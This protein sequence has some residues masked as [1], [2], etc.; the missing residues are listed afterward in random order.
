M[1]DSTTERLMDLVLLLLNASS[2]LTINQIRERVP[3]YGQDDPESF[4][5]MFERDKKALREA[6]IPLDTVSID[7]AQGDAQAYVLSRKDWLIPDLQLTNRERMLI[8][9]AATGWQ[10]HHMAQAAR[11]AAVHIGGRITQVNSK[12]QLRLGFD[13]RNLADVLEAIR[14]H[15]VLSFDYA[16]KSSGTIAKRRVDPWQA[17]CRSGAWY[18]IGFDHDHHEMRTFRISRIQGDVVIQD[19]EITTKPGSDFSL[20]GALEFWT[21]QVQEPIDVVLRVKPGTCGHIA[22][23]ADE[24]VVGHEADTIHIQ[25]ADIFGISRDIAACCN[26]VMSIEPAIVKDRVQE[27]V[28]TALAVHNT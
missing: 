26:E 28:A 12:N 15:K 3:G 14:Q 16:S 7:V 23:R 8:S 20:D 1:A 2:P 25:T 13:Q 9:F 5:R 22:V 18:L 10:N 24:V 17:V 19:A 21:K 6:N 11:E 27:L 4:K